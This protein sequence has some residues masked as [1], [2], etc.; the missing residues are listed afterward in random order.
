MMIPNYI[1]LPRLCSFL[2]PVLSIQ[3]SARCSQPIVLPMS[4]LMNALA[5]KILQSY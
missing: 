3:C 1:I 5:G 4:R 2:E